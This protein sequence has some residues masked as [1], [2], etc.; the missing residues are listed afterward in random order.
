MTEVTQTTIADIEVYNTPTQ[1][2][3][4]ATILAK[5]A[6]PWKQE[7]WPANR[8]RYNIIHEQSFARQEQKVIDKRFYLQELSDKIKAYKEYVEKGADEIR[9]YA[10]T[11]DL[12]N[13]LDFEPW[14]TWS[15][16]PILESDPIGAALK[17]MHS[18]HSC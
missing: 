4:R 2:S 5:V 6:P 17:W 15:I 13:M 11:H 1:N 8:E 9:E 14:D 10:K 7:P 12:D 3:E 16:D 18:D